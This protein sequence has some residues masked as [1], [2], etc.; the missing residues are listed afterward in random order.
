MLMRIGVI[1]WTSMI[2]KIDVFY[3]FAI[4]SKFARL[5]IFTLASFFDSQLCMWLVR[6]RNRVAIWILGQGSI[7]SIDI[8][9]FFL[10][11]L[12]RVW[13]SLSYDLNGN[14]ITKDNWH[15]TYDPLSRLTSA[16]NGE[17]T[18]QFSYDPLGRRL[19]KQVDNQ[20]P[21]HY[22][23]DGNRELGAYE[24]GNPK[25]LH[26]PRIAVEL[27]GEIFA[28]ILDCHGNSLHLVSLLSGSIA[29]SY[30]HT[31]FGELTSA[32]G[33]LAHPW[34]YAGKRLDPET[35][36][37]YFGHRYYDP[38][39]GRWLTTDPAGFRDSL[40]LYQY[41]LNNP[42]RYYDPDGQFA[43][44]FSIPL[45]AYIFEAALAFLVAPVS[46]PVLAA[47]AVGSIACVAIATHP[48]IIDHTM[49]AL[50][51]GVENRL[52]WPNTLEWRK[53]GS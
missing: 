36:F 7:R 39:I 17:T 28:P 15:Y 9:G 3:R 37:V 25:N 2:C 33:N 30:Q 40:N 5:R 41:V 53:R 51:R 45:T 22:L 27:E 48:Q 21:E 50:H 1:V 31:A 44:V 46:V 24:N 52:N 8:F 38:T 14:Q 20:L 6:F 23:Y 11:S 49:S 32:S 16:T 34:R 19:S 29:A 4:F 43:I 10:A 18:L 47:V 42:F 12:F 35:G 26:L 13:R